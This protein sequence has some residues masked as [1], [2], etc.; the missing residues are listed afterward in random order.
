MKKKLTKLSQDLEESTQRLREVVAK[1]TLSELRRYPERRQ[2]FIEKLYDP[3]YEP[4]P[5]DEIVI[6][7]LLE[8]DHGE[9]LRK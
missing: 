2:A 6:R 7:K 4:T 3:F 1:I 5:V 8:E 9:D